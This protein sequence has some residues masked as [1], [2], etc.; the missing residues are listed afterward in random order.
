MSAPLPD[1]S[2]AVVLNARFG[3][4]GVAGDALAVT[5]VTIGHRTAAAVLMQLRLGRR[6]APQTP[7]PLL[8]HAAEQ[9]ARY[10][11]GE[12]LDLGE[13][14]IRIG[15]QTPFQRRVREALRRVRYGETVSYAELAER[16]GAPRAARAVGSVMASNLLPLLIP[17]HRVIGTGGRL[18]GFSAPQGVALKQALLAMESGDPFPLAAL[19]SPRQ[20]ARAMTHLR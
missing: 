15:P 18:G 12:P 4:F 6:N 8:T 16:A 7:P 11:D 14:P 17:C 9:I 19:R 2:T 3:W 5:A 1:P 10:L 13:I 20:T